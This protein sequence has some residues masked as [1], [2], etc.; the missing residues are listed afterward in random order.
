[1]T[2]QNYKKTHLKKVYDFKNMKDGN[3]LTFKI[4]YVWMPS[5]SNRVWFS[6]TVLM[7]LITHNIP[8][9]FWHWPND[10]TKDFPDSTDNNVVL[11]SSKQL[12]KN[13][14]QEKENI[15]IR[16]GKLISRGVLNIVQNSA[17]NAGVK[18]AYMEW[19]IK[20]E[21]NRH[22]GINMKNILF[23]KWIYIIINDFVS[24]ESSM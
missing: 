16:T 6:I 10:H 18:D 3:S 2:K 23:I 19:Y 7:F 1:M 13:P 15:Q 17:L 8:D 4:V 24:P 12:V 11:N 21:R 22:K 14:S 9:E 20:I 5:T